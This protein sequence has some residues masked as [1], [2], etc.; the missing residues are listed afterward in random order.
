MEND[1]RIKVDVYYAG[2]DDIKEEN[3][4]PNLNLYNH[5]DFLEFRCHSCGCEG[6]LRKRENGTIDFYSQYHKKNCGAGKRKDY[7]EFKTGRSYF[8]CFTLLDPEKYKEEKA[9][10]LGGGSSVPRDDQEDF[11]SK[12][13][14]RVSNAPKAIRSLKHFITDIISDHLDDEEISLGPPKKAISILKKD[15]IIQRRFYDH[16][17]KLKDLNGIKIVFDPRPTNIPEKI[18]NQLTNT[19]FLQDARAMKD[20]NDKKYI[21]MLTFPSAKSFKKFSI[22]YFQE[23]KKRKSEET[24]KCPAI[25]CNLEYDSET[26]KIFGCDVYRSFVNPKAIAWLDDYTI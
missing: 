18:K 17:R 2:T 22:K 5:R 6:S 13:E 3:V 25:L 15:L 1:E 21:F 20:L 26:S 16:Y 9:A 10:I 12:T 7:I 19:L 11:I 23:N 14:V 8:D 24:F 4:I